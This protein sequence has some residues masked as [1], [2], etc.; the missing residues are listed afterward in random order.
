MD[1]EHSKLRESYATGWLEEQKRCN[2]V[3]WQS[4][5]IETL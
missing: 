5:Q 3:G 2:M 4:C 1:I